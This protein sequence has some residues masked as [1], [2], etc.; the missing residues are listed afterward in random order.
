LSMISSW[1]GMW[2]IASKFGSYLPVLIIHFS[3][4][5]CEYPEL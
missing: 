5:T 2:R 4:T 3:C 1:T